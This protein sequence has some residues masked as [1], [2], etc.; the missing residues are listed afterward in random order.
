MVSLSI[1]QFGPN[2]G[3]RRQD[4]ASPDKEKFGFYFS[5][6]SSS[7]FRGTLGLSQAA[8]A[9]QGPCHPPQ[10]AWAIW[11]HPNVPGAEVWEGGFGAQPVPPALP[12][13]L[14]GLTQP[15]L[16]WQPWSCFCNQSSCRGVGR[17]RQPSSVG[18]SVV[19]GHGALTVWQA[20]AISSH[21]RAGVEVSTG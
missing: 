13:C 11:D 19:L 15:S 3:G 10:G 6:C 18:C 9:L 4:Q 17:G 7:I 1:K 14:A 20:V 12:S 21:R 5:A 16:C 8:V 2:P